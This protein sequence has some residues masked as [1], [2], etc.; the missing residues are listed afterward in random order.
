MDKILKSNRETLGKTK[1]VGGDIPPQLHSFL[2]LYA[3]AKG[4]GKAETIREGLELWKTQVETDSK[5]ISM[6]VENI[7]I[8]WKIQKGKNRHFSDFLCSLTDELEE[9]GLGYLVIDKI[10]AQIKK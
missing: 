7:Q 6:L 8:A 4:I 10:T 2:C 1:H 3:T 9:K 5:L